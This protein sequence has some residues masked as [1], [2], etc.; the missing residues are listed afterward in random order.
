MSVEENKAL[1]RRFFENGFQE[2]M[3]GNVD[4]AREYFADNYRDHTSMH[5][6]Q[7]GV[8]GLKEIIADWGQATPDLRTEV[9]AIAG[10]DDLVFVHLRAT[11]THEAQHQVNKHV[12]DV[13]PTGEEG[14]V[15]GISLY[16]IEGGKFVERWNYHNVLEWALERGMAAPPDGSS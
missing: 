1:V 4:V 9:L 5:P 13:Q 14:T 3:R 16:R 8:Q 7:P 2:I 6:D 12:R 11:G 10:D 15:S